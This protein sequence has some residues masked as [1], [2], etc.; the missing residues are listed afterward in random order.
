MNAEA[1]TFGLCAQALP[2]EGSLRTQLMLLVGQHEDELAPVVN[3]YDQALDAMRERAI[4]HPTAFA[5]QRAV[6]DAM[7]AFA[8][9]LLY[10]YLRA[11]QT[12][13]EASGS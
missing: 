2:E 1:S 10:L 6:Y 5:D 4:A 13:P 7:V 8:T 9:R 3:A 11:Q 12:S